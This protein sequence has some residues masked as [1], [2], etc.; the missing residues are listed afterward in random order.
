MD[1][2]IRINLHLP[3]SAGATID[4]L[5]RERN[6]SRTALVRQALGVFEVVHDATKRGHFVGIVDD[7]EK[8]HTVLLTS[9]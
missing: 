5:C 1:D 6:L 9:F 3:A 4:R 7:Y 8:L 2:D